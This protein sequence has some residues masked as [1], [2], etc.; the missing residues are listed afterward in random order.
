MR[1]VAE[2]VARRANAE[3]GCKG[4]FW[5]GRFNSVKLCDEAAILACGIYV[6]LNVIRA[7]CAL[8]PETSE[9]TSAKLR[10]EARAE[11]LAPLELADSNVFYVP[12]S[13]KKLVC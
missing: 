2:P 13:L 9:H 12:D 11:W 8:S 3:Q 7:G 6:D 5:E 1:F 4:H 10:I